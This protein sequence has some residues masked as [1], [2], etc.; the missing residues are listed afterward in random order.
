[1]TM[2]ESGDVAANLTSAQH[3]AAEIETNRIVSEDSSHY[4]LIKGL[5]NV[6]DED[7]KRV[8]DSEQAVQEIFEQTKKESKLRQEAKE[9]MVSDERNL[10]SQQ[11][12]ERTEN[13]N[14]IG[15][16]EKTFTSPSAKYKNEECLDR[17]QDEKE[18]KVSV[19]QSTGMSNTETNTMLSEK[20][21]VTIGVGQ[22][23]NKVPLSAYRQL[24]QA[25]ELNLSDA[26][27]DDTDDS[28]DD[29]LANIK[30]L[31]TSNEMREIN[32]SV[33][34]DVCL[35]DKPSCSLRVCVETD[36]EVLLE[37]PKVE[38]AKRRASD[39]EVIIDEKKVPRIE[40][41]TPPNSHLN[42]ETGE[43]SDGKHQMWKR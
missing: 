9:K 8:K 41:N 34:G 7:E 40:P 39:A 23:S 12:S 4:I 37:K 24:P 15:N 13:L 36:S 25:E 28:G 29:A 42:E 18:S 14:E 33:A 16:D 2:Q 5:R 30:N 27:D 22:Q 32:N 21:L 1:M 3:V 31:K 10:V 35:E 26:D 38:C 20:K 17:S 19:G 43:M 11:E 6:E